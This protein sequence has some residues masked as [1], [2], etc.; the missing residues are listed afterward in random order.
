EPRIVSPP[1]MRTSVEPSRAFLKRRACGS[2]STPSGTCA[3]RICASSSLRRAAFGTEGGAAAISA[4]RAHQEPLSPAVG[5][6]AGAG[7]GAGATGA[8]AGG[9]PES[10]SGTGTGTGTADDG[11]VVGAGEAG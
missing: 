6:A 7:A 3:S 9:R 2:G 8:G 5:A 11:G 4:R 10:G 1:G